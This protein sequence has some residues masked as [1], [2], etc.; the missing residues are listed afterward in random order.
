MLGFINNT[1][2][3]TSNGFKNIED[4]VVGDYVLNENNEF[5][6][7]V[8]VETSES[9]KTFKLKGM[10]FDEIVCSP[11]QK[12]LVKEQY[13]TKN[14]DGK[15]VKRFKNKPVW[16]PINEIEKSDYMCIAVNSKSELPKWDGT[17]Y[18][19]YGHNRLLNTLEPLFENPSFWY[20]IGR[21]VGDG[22]TRKKY[23][24]GEAHRGGITI[25][26]S[27]KKPEARETLKDAFE[28]CGFNPIITEESTSYKISV[29][30]VELYDFV[31]RYAKGA[32]NKLIDGE[33]LSLPVELLSEFLKGYTDGN[34]TFTQDKFKLTLVS[35]NLIYS[36]AQCIAKVYKTHYHTYC[37]PM[38]ETCIIE[39]RVVN[40]HDQ[41]QLVWDTNREKTYKAFYED[42][43]IWFPAGK[44]V[45][46]T[47]PIT[48]YRLT[49]EDESG[50]NAFSVVTK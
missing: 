45:Q 43:H 9:N 38:P 49:T 25:S 34:G 33:T 39:G 1:L 40:C 42:G 44:F 22:W 13:S 36:I 4:V 14:G 8:N 37:N 7:V 17:H 19:Q 32:L 15:T 11:E 23:D 50:Y 3:Q 41:Y 28:K 26:C 18:N 31:E 35:R 47:E 10:C 24:N 21:Y 30:S 29:F 27:K 6:K 46:N 2:V 16:K 5:K 20:I 48:L 12:F